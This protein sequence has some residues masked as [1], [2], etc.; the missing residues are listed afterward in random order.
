MARKDLV[1]GEK[2]W[3]QR[4]RATGVTIKSVGPEGKRVEQTSV[5]EFK[6]FGRAQGVDGKITVTVEILQ[7][8][9]TTA[10]GT[11]RGFATTNDGETIVWKYAM[12]GVGE[13]S[14]GVRALGVAVLSTAS[15]KYSWMNGLIVVA[16]STLDALGQEVQNIYE[17][18]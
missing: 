1:V 13:P 12:V 6:G 14:K 15:M 11:G 3:E 8:A 5:R 4:G 17:W 9:D 7:E 10:A 18:K 2:L 16:E